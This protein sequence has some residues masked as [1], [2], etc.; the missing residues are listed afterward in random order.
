VVVFVVEGV[1]LFVTTVVPPPVFAVDV[2]TAGEFDADA[3]ADVE[4]DGSARLDV[5]AELVA[6]AVDIAEDVMVED[7]AAGDF[8]EPPLEIM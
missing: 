4:S 7:A 1:E 2:A 3:D 5:L 8:G 6:E